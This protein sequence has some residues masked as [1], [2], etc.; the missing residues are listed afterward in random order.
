MEQI[1]ASGGMVY[2]LVLEAS[3]ERIESSSLSLP[4]KFGDE[5]SM[6]MHWT[7]NPAP[8]GT[9]GS[10]PVV[11]TSNKEAWQSPAYCNSLENCRVERHREFESHRFRQFMC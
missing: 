9:T 2:T 1:W 6:V 4:T 11:S 3:A 5:A 10:I 7:V 8:N